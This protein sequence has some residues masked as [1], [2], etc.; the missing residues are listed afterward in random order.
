MAEFKL[1]HL[2]KELLNV[3][4]VNDDAHSFV[5]LVQRMPL[6]TESNTYG[7]SSTIFQN[8]VQNLAQ[9]VPNSQLF[10]EK[11]EYLKERNVDSLGEYVQLLNYISQDS[12]VKD[13][14]QMKKAR[15]QF[16]SLTTETMSTKGAIEQVKTR[17]K[18]AS[19]LFK[20][21]D[22]DKSWSERN[23]QLSKTSSITSWVQRRPSMSW[24]FSSITLTT[25][26]MQLENIPDISQENILIEDLLNILIGLPGCYIDPL[27]LQDQYATRE[28][29]LCDAIDPS[30]KDL[31][32]QI[33]PLASHYSTVQRF[34]EE[35]MRF[36]FG[37]V[38]NALAESMNS[39]IID[40]TLFVT[41]METEFRS[42][43][44]NLH[45]LWF[46]IQKNL[47]NMSFM[48]NIATSISKSDAK[49]GKVLSLL[50]DHITGYIGDTQAQQLCLHLM[51]A[52][53]VPYMNMLGMW[54]YK[55]I[56]LDPINEFL[57]E[58]N[59]MVQ[60]EEMPVDYSADYWDKKYT[61]RRERIPTFL[62]PVSDIILRAGKYLNVI[63]QCGKAVNHKVESIEY[64]IEQKHYI[65]AIDK[66]YKFASINLLDLVLKEKD[67]LGRLKSVKHYFLLDQGDFI[68]TFLTL[69]EKELNKD[70]ADVI[71]G[72][73][74]S[75]LDLALRLSSSNNDP[76][77][78]DLCTELLPYDLQHQM[79]KIKT[80]LSIEERN[81]FLTAQKKTNLTVIESFAFSYEVKWPLSLILNRRSLACY[82]MIFRHLFYCKH[83]ERMI[84]QVWRSNKVAKSFPFLS[85]KQYRL[86][87]A[88]RQ[89]MLHC[90]QNLEYHMMV[91][92]IEPHWSA[93]MQKIAK[94]SNV[95]EVLT[96]HCDF[97]DACLKDCMLTI[98][99]L[100]NTITNILAICVKFCK[101]MQ[102]TQQHFVEA[103][104]DILP[105]SFV[106]SF[107]QGEGSLNITDGQQQT[108][109]VE[110]FRES[111]A[112]LDLEFSEA[113]KELLEQINGLNKETSDHERLY[114]LLYRLDFN[115]YY[116]GQF[117]KLG[118]K[119]VRMN[120]SG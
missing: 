56:I 26:R 97:L 108:E 11:L 63:R 98:T 61:I 66:A 19:K 71:Q 110:S 106:D 92:V 22:L 90:I 64:K 113:L 87:F 30:L 4:G 28:F 17:V 84:C 21:R 12:R 67:L 117:E 100:L 25:S 9:V 82:Q 105:S 15:S 42:G 72:R 23:L 41:Q 60:K 7:C 53:C 79:V 47:H 78:D 14:L 37:Q 76:Y 43:N 39:L 80:V 6:R 83:V 119:N 38:C 52:A 93:F 59:E 46:Y 102:R 13:L 85:A 29:S 74:D 88:L 77:K 94:V 54:I 50:H 62:E 2:V 112:S 18:R 86:A 65:D 120:I 3:T 55:G 1:I 48:S 116:S 31:L 35:K 34:T 49:G 109:K 107:C 40:Y 24:D 10:L 58:D 75:L 95:D 99:S 103:E 36:E 33:L 68:V 104:L 91:E 57:I 96:C 32:K 115:S 114:N 81:L 27:K 45:K 51:Q 111:I 20:G 70:V 73:L 101:F 69:C 118:L 89:R 5:E 44:L 16:E 8:A